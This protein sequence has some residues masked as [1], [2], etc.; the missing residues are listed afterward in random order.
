[1]I[2]WVGSLP[3]RLQSHLDGLSSGRAMQTVVY[4][5]VIIL[6]T[7]L[8]GFTTI[9]GQQIPQRIDS[10]IDQLFDSR[11]WLQ[12]LVSVNGRD[13]IL[14]GTVQPRLVQQRDI[15]NVGKV[16]GV[17][18]VNNSLVE[19]PSPSAEFQ[20]GRRQQRIVLQGKLSG[21][22]LDR[23]IYAVRS[24]FPQDGIRDQIKI[25]DRLGP[26]LWLD[27][28][29]QGLE[30]LQ[31]LKEFTLH[32]WFDALLVDGIAE[33]SEVSEQV[34]YSMPAGLH[35]GIHIDYQ[36]RVTAPEGY[37]RLSLISGWNG[38]AVHG[39]VTDEGI[40][41][42]ITEGFNSLVAATDDDTVKSAIQ[43]DPGLIPSSELTRIADLI[44][45]LVRVHDLRLESS[46][47]RFVVSGRVDSSRQLGLLVEEIR[48]LELDTILDNQVYI[49]PANRQ[50]E[51]SIFRDRKRAVINGRL[52]SQ[53]ARADLLAVM[54]GILEVDQIEEFI[55]I[56]PNIRYSRWLDRWTMILPVLPHNIFGL[57]ISQD[58]VLVSGQAD[59]PAHGERIE[60]AL[61]SMFPNMR[62]VNWLTASP[63]DRMSA[64][65]NKVI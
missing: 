2:K 40:K 48:L 63:S 3:G 56:E 17:R 51:I 1:M 23:V 49:D 61:G 43:V 5:G 14:E 31:P 20:I 24:A 44:P 25:D 57:T 54:E 27:G 18:Q 62:Q 37:P 53:R 39:L 59:S 35:P 10:R 46:G 19:E 52:P 6:T 42:S 4:W 15:S 11:P 45:N 55:N 33:S 64:S 26:P 36:V 16:L 41:Q 8:I 12:S 32:G 34:R 21:A 47:S 7:L 58:A 13:V 29:G 22:D 38:A 30:A 9:Y 60:R 28:L 65:A 50:P